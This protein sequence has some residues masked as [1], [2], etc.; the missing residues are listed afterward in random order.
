VSYKSTLQGVSSRLDTDIYSRANK[1]LLFW[2]N[3]YII[4]DIGNTQAHGNFSHRH[5]PA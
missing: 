2:I 3:G 5:H 4:A 1:G